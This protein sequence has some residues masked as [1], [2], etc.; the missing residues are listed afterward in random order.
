MNEL[1]LLAHDRVRGAPVVFN[2]DSARDFL[3][4]RSDILCSVTT[5]AGRAPDFRCIPAGA[6]EEL[7]VAGKAFDGRV[8]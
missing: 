3:F 2:A 4:R 1:Y 5:S 6:L 8:T 7:I